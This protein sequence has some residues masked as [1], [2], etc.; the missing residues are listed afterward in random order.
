[1]RGVKVQPLSW[2]RVRPGP[3]GHVLGYAAVPATA[4]EEGVAGLGAARRDLA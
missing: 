1:A 3:P 4:I 2:H